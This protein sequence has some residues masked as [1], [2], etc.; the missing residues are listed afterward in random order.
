MTP[1]DRYWSEWS[2]LPPESLSEPGLV[3]VPHAR[4]RPTSLALVLVKDGTCIVSV[5]EMLV[6]EV[7]KRF[8]SIHP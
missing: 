3:V 1:I 2:G 4:A 5:P 7:Q 8:D 6:D